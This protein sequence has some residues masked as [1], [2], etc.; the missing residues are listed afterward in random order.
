VVFTSQRI[1][2]RLLRCIKAPACHDIH[3]RLQ[4]YVED[5]YPLPHN[6]PLNKVDIE[7]F[8]TFLSDKAIP[9]TT[10]LSL[11]SDGFNLQGHG[12]SLAFCLY[13]EA[14]GGRLSLYLPALLSLSSLLLA[15][16]TTVS[17][18]PRLRRCMN[19][20]RILDD[21]CPHITDLLLPPQWGGRHDGLTELSHPMAPE[22]WP[23]PNLRRITVNEPLAVYPPT[24]LPTYRRLLRKI[25][26][27]AKARNERLGG[28]PPEFKPKYSAV[29]MISTFEYEAELFKD[30]KASVQEKVLRSWVP[31]VS[32]R[33]RKEV[34]ISR[35]RRYY[36]PALPVL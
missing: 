9:T 26:N 17:V 8:S 13:S 25:L 23:F 14:R 27:I 19:L 7:S 30:K 21:S 2:T 6:N 35:S 22:K 32:I 16:V 33:P 5:G 34:P 3:V 15:S 36:N 12:F 11:N 28:S 29:A 31:E 18:D 10:T 4:H 24:N 1:V 20:V